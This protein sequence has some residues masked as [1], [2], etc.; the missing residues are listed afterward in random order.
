[1]I[2]VF[3]YTDHILHVDLTSRQIW[4]EPLSEELVRGYMGARGI[5]ARLLWDLL[6]RGID[7]LGPGNVLI[8]GT[9][10]ASGTHAP[11]SGRTTVTFKSPA[12][13]LYAKSSGGGH[14]G[15]ELKF[16]GYSFLVLHGRSDKPV[17][18]WIKDEKIEIRDAQ[19]LWGRD[20]SSTDKQLKNELG[21]ENLQTACI[22]QGGE[23]L[24][25]FAAVMLSVHC[26][27]ARAGGGAVMGSKNLKAIAVRGTGAVKAYD[28]DTYGDLVRS[29][30]YD[31]GNFP[32]RKRLSEFGTSSLIAIRNEMHLFPANN[33]KDSHLEGAEKVSGQYIKEKGYLKHRSG[34]G[35]C[36]TGCHRYTSI[37][38]GP[39][40]GTHSGGPE[41]ETVAALGPGCGV[42]DT[43]AV[44]KASQ[45]C[46]DFGLDTISAGGVI[47]WAMECYEKGLITEKQTDGLPLKWGDGAAV[48]IM[49]EKIACRKGL[50]NILAEGV[51]G[52]S[53]VIGGDS[54]KWA[55]HVKGLEYSR[56]DIRARTGYTLSLAV[57]PRGA[58]H[59]HSQVYAEFGGTPEARALI[60]MITGDEKYANALLLDKRADILR[61]HEDC[62]IISDNLGL[63]TF[64][65]L[66]HG[67]LITPERMAKLA[68]AL[69]GIPFTGEEA[70]EIGRKIMNLE[71]AF[72]VRE[73]ASRSDDYPAWRFMNEPINSGPYKGCVVKKEEFDGML[74]DYYTLHGWSLETSWPTEATLRG[75]GLTDV[76][77]QLKSYER[78]G[79]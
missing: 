12:T 53:R 19:H 17:Y 62:Y 61:W 44:L 27:A 78:I 49:L 79:S 54:W 70:M 31:L 3:G 75:V 18:L 63:C 72:N 10:V 23:N 66:G 52:A 68:T 58:D 42:I 28:P 43:E 40:A 39:Y 13:N 14:F 20:V 73:G 2:K 51:A 35:S 6:P 41:Y 32:S 15:P 16:A 48:V 64:S 25:K 38:S 21:D 7:P 5:N 36:A 26:A 46:N 1:M 69:T 71:K 77:D 29:A 22:G 76:A 8:F 67:Y 4:K 9:G 60:K 34:C 56:A 11:S 33:Y 74:N 55:M 24:V 65:T 57:N 50:G 47:Q 59:L 37:D 45:L 30:I